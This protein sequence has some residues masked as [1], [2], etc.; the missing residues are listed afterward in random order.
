MDLVTIQTVVGGTIYGIF[1]VGSIAVVACW[2]RIFGDVKASLQYRM[3]LHVVVFSIL[4]FTFYIYLYCLPEIP[5]GIIFYLMFSLIPFYSMFVYLIC[6]WASVVD[7]RLQSSLLFMKVCPCCNWKFSAAFRTMSCASVAVYIVAWILIGLMNYNSSPRTYYTLSLVGLLSTDLIAVGLI[8]RILYVTR[9]L[10]GAIRSS[11]MGD[12]EK[13]RRKKTLMQCSLIFVGCL[14]FELLIFD[15]FIIV[16][17]SPEEF[18]LHMSTP[19]ISECVAVLAVAYF[20]G[21]RLYTDTNRQKDSPPTPPCI[22]PTYSD[23][24]KISIN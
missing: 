8:G 6:T 4:K 9:Q 3:W 12:E 22:S 10:R 18:A 17:S 13:L 7:K 15:T 14:F 1:M 16:D 20:F 21:V 11:D 19:F 2:R 24:Q 5:T 23:D